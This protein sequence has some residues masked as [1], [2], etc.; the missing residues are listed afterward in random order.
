MPSLL[1]L[2]EMKHIDQKFYHDL[3]NAISSN[4]V[5]VKVVKG[6]LKGSYGLFKDFSQR[7]TYASFR[8]WSEFLKK[9]SYST[10]SSA[11]SLSKRH[12]SPK[13]IVDFDLPDGEMSHISLSS[14]EID[15]TGGELK[16]IFVGENINESYANPKPVYDA[17]GCEIKVGDVC[18]YVLYNH[19]TRGA[20]MYFGTVTKITPKGEVFA[21]DFDIG[22]FKRAFTNVVPCNKKVKDLSQLTILDNNVSER[23]LLTMLQN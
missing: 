9:P 15:F 14:C 8:A 4:H 16:K 13:I 6:P 22:T 5:Y 7:S 21:K 18:A 1:N 20:H 12:K 23:L 17:L 11:V 10:L 3:Y 19:R 2:N